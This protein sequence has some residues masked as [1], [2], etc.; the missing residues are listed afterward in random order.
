M[1]EAD[2]HL[3]QANVAR[4]LAPLDSAQ[5]EAFVDLLAPINAL[6]DA[7]PGFVWRLQDASGNATGIRF[8]PDPMVIVNLSVWESREALWQFVYRTRHMD[9]LRRRREWF[10]RH[11]EPYLVLWWLPTGTIPSTDDAHER[12]AALRS[13]GPTPFA[14]TFGE[15]FAA[16]GSPLR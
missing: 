14:F 3:A 15:G 9:L 12:L 7:S 10:E 5:L 1:T 6:A 13:R 16:D 11:L 8:A 2:V 4:L